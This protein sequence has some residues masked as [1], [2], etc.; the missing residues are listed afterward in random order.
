MERDREIKLKMKFYKIQAIYK[1]NVELV[2]AVAD[3][4]A[5]RVR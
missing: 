2:V 3:D 5:V 4:E 1:A